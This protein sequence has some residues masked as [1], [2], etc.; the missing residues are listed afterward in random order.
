MKKQPQSRPTGTINRKSERTRMP[1]QC[2]T[3]K[4]ENLQAWM[5]RIIQTAE[6]IHFHT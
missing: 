2:G 4:A 3:I 1:Q 5:I 6:A